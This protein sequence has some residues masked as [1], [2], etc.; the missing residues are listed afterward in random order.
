MQDGAR[1]DGAP[2]STASTIAAHQVASFRAT[3]ESQRRQ[4]KARASF[5][6]DAWTLGLVFLK[7]AALQLTFVLRDVLRDV[8]RVSDEMCA[9]ITMRRRRAAA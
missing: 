2:A 5:R 1:Q 9:M 8:R 7:G 4:A 3:G 6:A